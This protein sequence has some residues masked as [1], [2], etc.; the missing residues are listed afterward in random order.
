MPWLIGFAGAIGG[1][2]AGLSSSLS[3]AVFSA[4][5]GGCLAGYWLSRSQKKRNRL[6]ASAAQRTPGRT[7]SGRL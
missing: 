2:A 5:V 3:M 1:F 7:D 6:N 4:V